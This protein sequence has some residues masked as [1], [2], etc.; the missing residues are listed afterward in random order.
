MFI[1]KQIY[2]D[3]SLTKVEDSKRWYVKEK[4]IQSSVTKFEKPS[5]IALKFEEKSLIRKTG[6]VQSN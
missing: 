5:M 6:G 3:Y 1:N 4:W 2:V